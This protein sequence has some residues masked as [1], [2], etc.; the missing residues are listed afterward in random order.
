MLFIELLRRCCSSAVAYSAW[1]HKVLFVERATYIK[2]N[3]LTAHKL[4]N[5]L[6]DTEHV[7]TSTLLPP[8][9]PHR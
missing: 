4:I 9:P 8:T 7:H 5:L 3:F 6:T 2:K 1:H